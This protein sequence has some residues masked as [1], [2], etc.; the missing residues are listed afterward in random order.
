MTSSL[1]SEQ[2]PGAYDVHQTVLRPSQ[3]ELIV[4]RRNYQVM[5]ETQPPMP[6][7]PAA[8]R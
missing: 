4:V 7:G 6:N 8:R 2:M 1:P 3:D 5:S